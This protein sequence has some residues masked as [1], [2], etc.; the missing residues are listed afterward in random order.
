MEPERPSKEQNRLG[1]ALEPTVRV[2]AIGLPM[3]LA[4]RNVGTSIGAEWPLWMER[5]MDIPLGS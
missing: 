3:D 5:I 1:S 2:T 4:T